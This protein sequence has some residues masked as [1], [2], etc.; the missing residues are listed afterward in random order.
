MSCA[1]H[2]QPHSSFHRELTTFPRARHGRELGYLVTICTEAL[3]REFVESACVDMD[4]GSILFLPSGGNTE[5]QTSGYI[6]QLAMSSKTELMQVCAPLRP[7]IWCPRILADESLRGKQ[8]KVAASCM[9]SSYL[10]AIYDV[11]V[12]G[13]A[14]RRC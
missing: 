4:P 8:L 9:L 11:C 5:L 7:S 13:T 14:S 3:W 12:V 1:F 2:R 6:E 10:P